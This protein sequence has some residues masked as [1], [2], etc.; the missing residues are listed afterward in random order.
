M[1]APPIKNKSI[2]TLKEYSEDMRKAREAFFKK[3]PD[4]DG[5]EFPKK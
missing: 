1:K 5:K 3:Y 2:K 4:H